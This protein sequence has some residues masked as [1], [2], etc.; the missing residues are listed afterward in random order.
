MKSRPPN[1]HHPMNLTQKILTSALLVAS[2][3]SLHAG[4]ALLVADAPIKVP[5]SSGGF[6][7]LKIDAAR[8][9][10]LANHTGNNSLD[11]FDLADGKLLKHIPTGKAQDVAV[12]G[13]AG[14]YLVGVSKEQKVVVVDAEKLE[15]LREIKLDGPADAITF[16]PKQHELY[17][18]HDDGKDLWVISPHENKVITTIAIA[19][20]PEVVI[21][22]AASDRIF[23]NIKSN[24]TVLVIDPMSHQIKETWSTAPATGPHGLAYNPA[25]SH[26]F[27]AGAN[28]KLAVLDAKSGKNVGSV[29]IA[30]GVDQIVFDSDQQRVYSA[31]GSGKICITQDSASGPKSLGEVDSPR[32]AKTLAYDAKA[33]AVWVAYADGSG[34]YIQRF[35]V[36]YTAAH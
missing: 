6:D 17:V 32:G 5:D 29:D 21:Y 19:E 3:S 36:K 13:E 11:V 15:V 28:G 18:G 14:T 2:V 31:C 35:R 12:D 24:A 9:R 8:N 22:D 10:L 7:F 4:E 33:H 20:A 25:T 1:K 27:C 34:S 16:T 26:L 23:Q 30:K